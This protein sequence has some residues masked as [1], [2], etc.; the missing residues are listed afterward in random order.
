VSFTHFPANVIPPSVFREESGEEV[1]EGVGGSGIF[2]FLSMVYSF[3]VVEFLVVHF[4]T[5]TVMMEETGVV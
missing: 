3:T 4:F 2:F 1:E 5:F